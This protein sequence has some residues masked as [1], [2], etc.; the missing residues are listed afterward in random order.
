MKEIFYGA[1]IVVICLC[2][3]FGMYLI[4]NSI[5]LQAIK[6]NCDQM[7]GTL[8]YEGHKSNWLFVTDIWSCKTERQNCF[9]NGV[10]FNCSD[11]FDVKKMGDAAK[12]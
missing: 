10:E 4:L 12:W 3:G 9:N 1:A 11:I 7:N 2:M 5:E 8:A 6:Y